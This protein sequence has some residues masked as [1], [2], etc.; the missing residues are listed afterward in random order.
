MSA[1]LRD[2]NINFGLYSHMPEVHRFLCI[3]TDLSYL[4]ILLFSYR[5]YI[6][7]AHRGLVKVN[8]LEMEN[9]VEFPNL[10]I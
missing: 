9:F 7:H 4:D 6:R 8:K 5:D 1:N 3:P 10:Q 2:L